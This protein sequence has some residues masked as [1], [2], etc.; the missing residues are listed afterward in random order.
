MKRRNAVVLLLAAL[1][2]LT[3]CAVHKIYE[4][5]YLIAT[6]LDSEDGVKILSLSIELASTDL[7]NTVRESITKDGA[8]TEEIDITLSDGTHTGSNHSGVNSASYAG[9]DSF[10]IY[11]SFDE[12]EAALD[13]DLLTSAMLTYPEGENNLVLYYDAGEGDGSIYTAA[14]TIADG[15]DIHL[16]VYMNFSGE[17]RRYISNLT[18]ISDDIRHETYT[19]TAGQEVELFVDETAGQACVFAMEN[20]VSYTWKC[21]GMLTMD[22]ARQ[23][24]DTLK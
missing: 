14:V 11:S 15:I 5:D 22:W 13:R 20:G 16:S 17:R 7:P 4:N 18:G 21:K 12:L 23:F 1:L 24:A 8:L 3:G 10:T 9:T 19:T 2:A 6:T